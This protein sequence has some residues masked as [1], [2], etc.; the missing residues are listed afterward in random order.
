M[1]NNL[2]SDPLSCTLRWFISGSVQGTEMWDP[3][4][5]DGYQVVSEAIFSADTGSSKVLQGA[6]VQHLENVTGDPAACH[7]VNSDSPT[8]NSLNNIEWE[9]LTQTNIRGTPIEKFTQSPVKLGQ[10]DNNRYIQDEFTEKLRK[11]IVGRRL[12]GSDDYVEYTQ[13]N[14]FGSDPEL[15]DKTSDLMVSTLQWY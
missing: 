14:D 9:R 6:C 5:S 1:I 7:F 13:P 10:F 8:I 11:S 2:I 15:D 3:E 4:L 12:Q